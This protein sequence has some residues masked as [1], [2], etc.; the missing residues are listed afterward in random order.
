V[1]DSRRG[2]EH[3]QHLSRRGIAST[4][5]GVAF[6]KHLSMEEATRTERRQRPDSGPLRERRVQ[7]QREWETER[8]HPERSRDTQQ[9]IARDADRGDAS[10]DGS[11]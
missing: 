10:R 7:Q 4:A 5:A 11:S 3:Q 2:D 1:T 9:P 8:R 6:E